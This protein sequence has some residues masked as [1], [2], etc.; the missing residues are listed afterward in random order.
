[1]SLDAS[2]LRRALLHLFGLLELGLVEG[3]LGGSGLNLPSGLFQADIELL[4]RFILGCRRALLMLVGRLAPA[5]EAR[6]LDGGHAGGHPAGPEVGKTQLQ[7]L[8]RCGNGCEDGST[9]DKRTKI[10]M[11]SR[12]RNKRTVKVSAILTTAALPEEKR[13]HRDLERG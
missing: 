7:A 5:L 2:G 12:R 9:K 1:M 6:H 11:Y 13:V 3:G 4:P 8:F 10:F